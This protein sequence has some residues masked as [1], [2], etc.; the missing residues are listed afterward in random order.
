M[1]QNIVNPR[2]VF[3]TGDKMAL[4]LSRIA[5]TN[6]IKAEVICHSFVKQFTKRIVL[7]PLLY[8]SKLMLRDVD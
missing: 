8:V 2:H 5:K 1:P 7:I 3:D 6:L 4:A